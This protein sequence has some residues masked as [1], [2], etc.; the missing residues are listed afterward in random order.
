[1][2]SD[3]AYQIGRTRSSTGSSRPPRRPTRALARRSRP[4]PSPRA[5]RSSTATAAGSWRSSPADRRRIVEV[6]TAIGYS[7]LWMALGPAGG[8]HDRRRSI[9]DRD[10][11]DRARGF[12]RRGRDRRRADHGRQRAGARRVRGR[13][14]RRSPGPFDLAFIDALKPEYRGLSSR[15]LVPRLA[16]GRPGRR[17]QRPLE[18]PRLGATKPARRRRVHRSRSARFNAGGPRATRASRRRSC[19]SA[20]ACSSPRS[21]R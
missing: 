1:M 11:T 7:T 16:P 18:R 20:T 3:A 8:R 10:R 9:P 21:A 4:P 12:W 17:R 13:R 2:K 15:R 5:S 6:G 19:R 14:R